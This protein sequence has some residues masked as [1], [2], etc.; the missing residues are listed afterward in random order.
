MNLLLLAVFALAA[1][2]AV[3]ADRYVIENRQQQGKY[4]DISSGRT[5][6]SKKSSNSCTSGTRLTL[7][8]LKKSDCNYAVFRTDDWKYG[9]KSFGTI[10][11]YRCSAS[12]R[13]DP[14]IVI[15]LENDSCEEGT[16]IVIKAEEAKR[17]EGKKSKKGGGF[18]PAVESQQWKWDTKNK[19][20]KNVISSIKCP[21]MVIGVN[22]ERNL[23]L[24]ERDTSNRSQ[25]WRWR[26][27]PDYCPWF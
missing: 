9:D 5:G 21:G 13:D 27:A 18:P 15:G 14:T 20:G 4:L 7:R 11:N 3:L 12:T 23:V 10:S 1:A 8:S 19:K 2:P 24:Q 25:E 22:R 17:K 26:T 16:Q 6:R